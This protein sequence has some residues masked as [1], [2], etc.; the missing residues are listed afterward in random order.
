MHPLDRLRETR[1]LPVI[2][3]LAIVAFTL[4][5]MRIASILPPFIWA[6]ITAYILFPIVAR[7]ERWLRA[8]RVIAIILVYGGLIGTLVF[9]GFQVAPT[10]VDQ[11]RSLASSL[12]QLVTNA[13]ESL[14]R[15]PQIHL[16]GFVIDTRQ[17]D[18]RIDVLAQQ[19]AERFGREAV[20]LVLQTFQ[21]LIKTLVYLLATFYFLLQGD[22]LVKRLH[23]L[24]PRRHRKTV[25]KIVAQV[26]ETFGAY[27]R[28][29]VIL[30]AIMTIS[31]L[32]VL[33]ILQVQYALVVA[34]AT[35]VLELVPIIGPWAA[36]GI[37]VLVA[38]SQ[39]SGPFGWSPTQL[40]LV[41][42]IC[43]L[44]LRLLEDQVIIPQ[45]I[46]RIVRVHPLMV[47]FG[48]LTGATLG[49]ALGLVIAVPVMAA[50]KIISL[51]IFEVMRHPQERVVIALRE[52][53]SLS[54]F[55]MEI[56]KRQH[57]RVVLL[58]APNAIT[59]EDLQ[60]VQRIAAR[61]LQFDINL[62]MVTP[63]RIIAS[64]A[65]AAGIEVL[66]QDRLEEDAGLLND[67]AE[68]A[69]GLAPADTLEPVETR[70]AFGGTTHG[71]PAD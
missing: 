29:Q 52:P 62:Q 61:A 45:L 64:I 57:Q 41:V 13:R 48:V 37:A 32:T 27:I 26:N 47:I 53:G 38:V 33:S 10:A 11:V 46:G 43:Y 31:T 39:S 58:A 6:A 18:S 17:I 35:G 5:L 59:W 56:G 55:E 69:A 65:T 22:T 68:Y 70:P 50:V 25:D 8:P 36:G 28:A 67:T 19:V 60:T 15:E 9:I 34:I 63:D 20:P 54:T 24:A 23:N 40:A 66:T 30:F 3:G 44:I 4:F 16:G 7:L 1:L 12:P 14:V 21:L 71:R 51:A 49:G 42:G 2:V